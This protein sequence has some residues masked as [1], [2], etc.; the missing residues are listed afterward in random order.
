LETLRELPWTVMVTSTGVK[1]PVT[2]PSITR[3]EDWGTGVV[4]PPA[5][6]TPA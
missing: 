5:H 1:K 4:A 6:T 3:A 2:S